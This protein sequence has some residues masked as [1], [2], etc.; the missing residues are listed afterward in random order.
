MKLPL[1]IHVRKRN[2]FLWLEQTTSIAEDKKRSHL[3]FLRVEI[4]LILENSQLYSSRILNKLVID[5]DGVQSIPSLYS[6][7]NKMEMLCV[8]VP[9]K[10]PHYSGIL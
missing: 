2:I 8:P 9:L 10:V 3:P 5:I 7:S 1:H 6:C 4:L